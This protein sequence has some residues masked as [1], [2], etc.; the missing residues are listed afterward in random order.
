MSSLPREQQSLAGGILSAVNKLLSNIALSIS[1][2]VYYAG[3]SAAGDANEDGLAGYK[4]A[5]WMLVGIAGVN[6]LLVPFLRIERK[7]MEESKPL[8]E[9]E[10]DGK[11]EKEKDLESGLVRDGGSLEKDMPRDSGFSAELERDFEGI[12]DRVRER[13]PEMELKMDLEKPLEKGLE[14]ATEKKNPSE[15]SNSAQEKETDK[16]TRRRSRSL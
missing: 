2:A 3:V 10:G 8:T 4:A 12:L 6:L 5:F 15:T 7:V 9:K 11:E 1:T 14:Q 13:G 16:R